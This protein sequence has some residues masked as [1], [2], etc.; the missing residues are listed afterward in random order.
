MIV[1]IRGGIGTQIIEMLGCYGMAMGHGFEITGIRVNIGNVLVDARA[2]YVSSVFSRLPKVTE[3][4]GTKKLGV[5]KDIK[6][7]QAILRHRTE[8]LQKVGGLKPEP[9]FG[10][11]RQ[12]VLHVRAGNR[13]MCDFQAYID[14][15]SRYECALVGNVRAETAR[16]PGEDIS[17][18]AP[19]HQA[20]V[21]DWFTVFTSNQIV[22]TAS[23]FLLSMLFIN[24]LKKIAM[25]PG[26][27]GEDFEGVYYPMM[28]ALQGSFPNLTW[29]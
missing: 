21:M 11:P 9:A 1:D 13:C 3:T 27:S 22:G 15:A 16:V 2:D 5:W 6:L 26:Q 14:Y 10:K 23:T 18:A 4:N 7:L 24:P 19:F 8:I 12:R 17:A 29:L 28:R 25:L 20:V